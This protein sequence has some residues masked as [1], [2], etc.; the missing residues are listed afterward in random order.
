MLIPISPRF[1]ELQSLP[2]YID[3]VEQDHS[4]V[5]NTCSDDEAEEIRGMLVEN[6]LVVSETHVS[7]LDCFAEAMNSGSGV[8]KIEPNGK[9][10]RQIRDLFENHVLPS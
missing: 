4:I 8:T 6:D 1:P 5:L 2:K 10:T 9:A 3:A 7:R